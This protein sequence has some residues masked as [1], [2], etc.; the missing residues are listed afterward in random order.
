MQ[1]LGQTTLAS[2]GADGHATKAAIGPLRCIGT[3]Q[4]I[5]ALSRECVESEIERATGVID[6]IH[7]NDPKEVKIA[8]ERICSCRP[9]CCA[10]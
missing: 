8:C 9:R 10:S 4:S 3:E 7:P 1:P 5:S 2:A 6:S